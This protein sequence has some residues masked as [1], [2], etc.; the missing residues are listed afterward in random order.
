MAGIRAMLFGCAEATDDPPKDDLNRAAMHNLWPLPSASKYY[1]QSEES[2]DSAQRWVNEKRAWANTLPD[3]KTR[4]AY[5]G[6]IDYVQGRINE[7][8][9]ENRTHAAAKESAARS[10]KYDAEYRRGVDLAPSLP[11]PPR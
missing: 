3:R 10:A 6:W 11:K 5:I 9:E 4:N 2:L 1:P 7:N 8:R